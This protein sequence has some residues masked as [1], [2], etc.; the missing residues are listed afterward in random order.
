MDRVSNDN[1]LINV[2]QLSGLVDAA[3]DGK[4]FCF[5]GCDIYDMMDHLD[6]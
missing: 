6:N 4:K 3:S 2:R 1:D 5:S